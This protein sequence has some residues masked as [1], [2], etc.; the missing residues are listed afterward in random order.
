[1]A[2]V[3]AA[4][5]AILAE[6][7]DLV[8]VQVDELTQRAGALQRALLTQAA[9]VVPGTICLAV[10]FFGLVTRPMKEIGRAIRR[11][12]AQE[13][14]RRISVVGPCDVQELGALLEW[15]RQ[16]IQHLEQQKITFL[17]H[18]SHELKT[19]LT[20]IRTGSE[21]LIEGLSGSAGE[22]AELSR[23]IHANGL[24]LEGLI[25]DLL[26]FS[27]TQKLSAASDFS[28]SVDLVALVRAVAAAQSLAIEAGGLTVSADLSPARVRGDENKLRI[29]V[30][31]LLT[32]AAKF[33]P[34]GGQIRI[35]LRSAG[36]CAVLDIEDTGPGIP[37]AEIEKIFEPFQR[38]SAECRSSVK[39]TGLGLSIAKE[40][41]E[42]HQGNIGVVR[43]TVGAHFRVSIPTMGPSGER[44]SAPADVGDGVLVGV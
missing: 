40:Y 19:P 34:H 39:G 31:N 25:E 4:G 38:G 9:A 42:A 27:E 3:Q 26:R 5:R 14:S 16:R 23:I 37:A 22:E 1:L 35:S 15:L 12:G 13:F 8:D 43:S 7:A 36:S 30:D 2:G 33:T 32:N 41:V 11:L 21:L 29:V 17:R 10:L 20:T 28:D 44:G 6:S 18:I 24:E